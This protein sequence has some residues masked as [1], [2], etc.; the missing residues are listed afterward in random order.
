MYV[1]IIIIIIIIINNYKA[2]I[3]I[4]IYVH[5]S[6]RLVEKLHRASVLGCL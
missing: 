5:G 6:L 2:I 1:I 4:I 3:T